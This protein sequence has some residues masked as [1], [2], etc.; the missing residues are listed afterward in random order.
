MIES[1]AMST[2]DSLR[3]DRAIPRSRRVRVGVVGG[4]LVSQLVHLPLLRERDDLFQ[5][6]GLAE[7]SSSTRQR[8]AARFGI[9]EA[10]ADHRALFDAAH[11][12]AVLIA[13]PNGAHAGQVLDA[14]AAGLH[15]LVE[16]P[17]CLT[18]A[19]AR[20]IAAAR[21]RTGLVVQVG[22]MKRY[23][24][25]FEALCAELEAP[26]IVHVESITYDPG[27]RTYFGPPRDG[28]GS[29]PADASQLVA[30]TL[31][32]A[33]AAVGVGDPR[34]ATWWSEVFLGALVHDVNLVRAVLG[35]LRTPPVRVA[36][37]FAGDDRAG[38]TL[39]LANG[40]RWTAAWLALPGVA[41]FSERITLYCED[42]IRRLEFP[43]PYLRQ[44]PTL[45]TR[46]YERDG[47]HEQRVRGSWDE[48][49][50]KALRHF[51]ACLAGEVAC[52]TPPEQA[53]EDIDLLADLFRASGACEPAEAAA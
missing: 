22:Y 38:G 39:E 29:E 32:Q 46:A 19:D 25:A 28:D 12:D 36:D 52:R 16:K 45:Y 50:E 43:A 3:A 4:G 8:V 35:R 42:G 21:E 6:A 31:E 24:P 5:V 41:D 13:S 1:P 49:Y 15:V 23:D 9:E 17:L 51:R 10:T 20:R 40:A 34:R 33:R 26:Q 53:A 48:A 7:P 30:R 47:T 44:A 14:L 2:Q 27:L 37:A 11:L 18:P